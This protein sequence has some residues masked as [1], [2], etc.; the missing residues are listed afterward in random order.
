MAAQKNTKVSAGYLTILLSYS[1]VTNMLHLI[2]VF[3]YS[4][5]QEVPM[6]SRMH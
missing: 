4:E 2:C 5:I 6:A 3:G 1:K